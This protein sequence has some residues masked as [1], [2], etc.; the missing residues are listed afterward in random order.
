MR[1]VPVFFIKYYLLL[2]RLMPV[3]TA[4]LRSWLMKNLQVLTWCVLRD[5]RKPAKLTYGFACEFVLA[6]LW[7]QGH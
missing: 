2:F 1:T 5:F 4:Q 7:R 3:K 6:I